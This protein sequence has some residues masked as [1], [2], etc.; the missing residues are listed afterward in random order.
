MK[1]IL[2][3]TLVGLL[4]VLL[5]ACGKSSE[6]IKAE[7]LINAIGEVSLDSETSIKTVQEYYDALTEKQREQV[8]NYSILVSAQENL[9][10]ESKYSMANKMLDDELYLDAIEIFN[11]LGTYKDSKTQVLFSKYGMADKMLD[12]RLYL[13][14]IE[15]FDELGSYSDSVTKSEESKY[16]YILDLLESDELVDARR[17]MED[18]NLSGYKDLGSEVQYYE[19]LKN[20]G[21]TKENDV[22]EFDDNIVEKIIRETIGKP[23]EDINLRDMLKIT[24]LELNASESGGAKGID[25]KSREASVK[26]IEA[27]KYCLNLESIQVS[28]NV[29]KDGGL[30]ALDSKLSDISPLKNLKKLENIKLLYTQVTDITPLSDHKNVK[31]LS[32]RTYKNYGKQKIIGIESLNQF[33]ALEIFDAEGYYLPDLSF[34]SGAKTLKSIFVQGCS[35]KDISAISNLT[36]LENVTLGNIN[37]TDSQKKELQEALPNCEIYFY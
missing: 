29:E 23:A 9:A 27:I 12:N 14:A 17:Y 37:I 19:A 15:I 36:D 35:T 26:S 20:F 18:Q 30:W 2:L 25:K 31:S 3:M 1:K 33:T 7:E 22:I 21:M 11:E 6:V 13:D 34:L 4:V 5:D 28:H 16:N 10:K 24:S 32:L 8:E